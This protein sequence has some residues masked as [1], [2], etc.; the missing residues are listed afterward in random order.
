MC[1]GVKSDNHRN[2]SSNVV[3]MMPAN[4]IVMDRVSLL[5]KVY[6]GPDGAGLI[7]AFMVIAP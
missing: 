6:G 7:P 2:T 1:P 3:Y 4:E 5:G